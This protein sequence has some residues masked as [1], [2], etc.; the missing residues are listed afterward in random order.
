MTGQVTPGT[1]KPWSASSATSARLQTR[2]RRGMS[3]EV[4]DDVGGRL[5]E[6]DEHAL[7]RARRVGV[8]LGVDEADVVTGRAA[9]DAAG[10]EADALGR[11]PGDG[12]GEVIDPE[13][14]VVEARLVDLGR[15]AGVDRLHEVD[16]DAGD[17]EDVLVDVLA[18]AAEAAGDGQAEELDPELAQ[19]GFAGAADR[20]LLEA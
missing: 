5:D 13:A 11:E 1:A 3:A 4:G 2:T 8:A 14:E 12:G 6:L 17:G 10:G 19:G 16:L 20:D 15:H 18:L 7:A 9:P